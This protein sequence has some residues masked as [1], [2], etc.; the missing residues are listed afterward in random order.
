MYFY[1]H[2]HSSKREQ[3][4]DTEFVLLGINEFLEVK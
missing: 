2:F 1:G 3:I 4:D